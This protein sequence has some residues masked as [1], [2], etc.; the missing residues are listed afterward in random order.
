[1]AGQWWEQ[2]A[3]A[4]T[5]CDREGVILYMNQKAV[6]TFAKYGGAELV[7]RNLLD[8]HPEPARTKLRELM[9]GQQ[10]NVYTIEK[11]GVKKLIHQSPWYQDGAYA[12]LV[13]LS[14]E[15]PD[16]MPHHVRG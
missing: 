9:A 14:L 2:F 3:G 13:E 1:M 12:G 16:Q 10:T 5:V 15:I 4:V 6:K 11:A 8:C 7:G